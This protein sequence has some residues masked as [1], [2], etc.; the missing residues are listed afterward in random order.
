MAATSL[1][2]PLFSRNFRIGRYNLFTAEKVISMKSETD[3]RCPE[4]MIPLRECSLEQAERAIS[5]GKPLRAR[6]DGKQKAVGRTPSVMMREDLRCAYPIVDGI[7]IL[8][9]PE[10]LVAGENGR[11]F[12]LKD[13]KWAEA[14]EEMEHYN[15]V[16]VENASKIDAGTLSP[17]PKGIAGYGD[18]FP[19]PNR[20][21]IDAPHDALAQMDAY[22]NLGRIRGKRVAVVGGGGSHAVK[23][24][25]A[26]A[27]EA[28]LITP[29]V[30]ECICGRAMARS[31]GVEDRLRCVVAV[32]EQMPLRPDFLD[33]IYS[34]G[35]IHHMV[36]ELVAKE[37]CRVLAPGGHFTAVD[38][39]RTFLHTVGTRI[40]GKREENV[41]C[42]PMTEERLAPF[43]SEFS[44]FEVTHY[45][46]ILRYFLLGVCKLLK[47]E[48]SA[49]LGYRL[50]QLEDRTF[51]RV[52]FFRDRGGSVVFTCTKA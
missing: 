44:R 30:G 24:L 43:R 35:C 10:M 17:F 39:W 1:W 45:G 8:L 27:S 20:I 25:L 22:R 2:E 4:T 38:P 40:L 29:M 37:L 42:K 23:F 51:G 14:Y 19:E 48:M 11:S 34:G 52:P 32:G 12:N 9:L 33:A 26:G 28:W 49:G 41:Y 21:W 31:F 47:V 15:A 36:A 50:G 46:P 18:S 6:P 13:S 7:P 3:L 5:D 16:G